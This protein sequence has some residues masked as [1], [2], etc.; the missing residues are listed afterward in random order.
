VL[1]RVS[2]AGGATRYEAESAS[3]STGGTI[4]ANHAGY[5]GTGFANAANAVGSYV[6]WQVN[7]PAS[8]LAFGY[9]NGTAAARPVD[10]SVDGTVVA[11]GVP[12]PATGAWTTWS[13]VTQP[14]SLAA[15]THTVRLTA[16]TADGPANLDYLD[17]SP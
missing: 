13:T 8:T 16:T 12:F 10:I 5:S 7:G 14:V 9:A 11:T 15:G 6:E 3:L 17:V 4:D 2:R 1:Y